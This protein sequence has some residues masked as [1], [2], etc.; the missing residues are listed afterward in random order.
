[1][2]YLHSL[3]FYGTFIFN[4]HTIHIWRRHRM[5][6]N[7]HFVQAKPNSTIS[8]LMIMS[9]SLWQLSCVIKRQTNSVTFSWLS[10]WIQQNLFQADMLSQVDA[11]SLKLSMFV[12]FILIALNSNRVVLVFRPQFQIFQ[13]KR[14]LPSKLK[15]IIQGHTR[16]KWAGIWMPKNINWNWPWESNAV[17]H[18]CLE[19]LIRHNEL[20]KGSVNGF[21]VL[22]GHIVWKD[23]FSNPEQKEIKENRPGPGA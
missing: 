1:M 12:I 15:T 21:L 20:Y 2:I 11:D 17:S 5:V 8:L 3:R 10:S 23:F 13:Q 4:I 18:C 9:S 14:N 19:A 6:S 7:V 16:D 22:F